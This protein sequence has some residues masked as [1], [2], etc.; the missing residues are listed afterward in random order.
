MRYNLTRHVAF[1][2]YCQRKEAWAE[3]TQSHAYPSN[4]RSRWGLFFSWEVD[5]S[6]CELRPDTYTEPLK[7][8]PG[9]RKIASD[10]P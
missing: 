3:L 8:I 5:R 4:Q 6:Y 9:S 10:E 2:F 1:E 7:P